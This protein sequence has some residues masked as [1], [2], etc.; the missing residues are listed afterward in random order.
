MF[1]SGSKA[2]NCKEIEQDKE[3]FVCC[4]CSNSDLYFA[5]FYIFHGLQTVGYVAVIKL[6]SFY[7]PDEFQN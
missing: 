4:L 7:L 6:F 5:L 2:R 3:N 1:V